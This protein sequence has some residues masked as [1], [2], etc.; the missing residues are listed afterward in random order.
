MQKDAPGSLKTL[1]LPP[2]GCGLGGLDW[3][4]VNYALRAILAP[5]VKSGITIHVSAEAPDDFSPPITFAG[6]G[7]RK[8]PEDIC[9]KMKAL[10]HFASEEGWILRSG[11]A[12]GS[13][14]AF[15]S[16][17]VARQ[18]EIFT[19]K[20]NPPANHIHWITDMHRRIARI[21]HPAPQALSPY[22][23]DLMARNCSQ[24]LG[25]HLDHPSDLVICWTPK[26]SGTGG[27]G[28][29]IRIAKSIG[30]PVIDLGNP[31]IGTQSAEEIF[32]IARQKANARRELLANLDR[33]IFTA[34][35]PF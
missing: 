14:Q 11:G 31:E 34:P 6:I 27:T 8:T 2:P 4:R 32:E 21:Y 20:T 35:E 7:A 9:S 33:E 30:I 24:V 28:Q 5:A 26:G 16:G 25:K 29:A 1:C 17:M 13:D 12:V 18:A 10:S 3:G 15:E 22:A 19:A 23:L